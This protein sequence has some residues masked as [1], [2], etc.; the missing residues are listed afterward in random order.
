MFMT[1]Y[2]FKNSRKIHAKSQSKLSNLVHMF[3]HCHVKI[4][5]IVEN[6]AK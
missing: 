1:K 6:G 4:M 2:I 5:V 3:V